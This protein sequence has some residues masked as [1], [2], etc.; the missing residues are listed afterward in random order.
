MDFIDDSFENKT[1]TMLRTIKR[2]TRSIFKP[3]ANQLLVEGLM[4]LFPDATL[5]VNSAGI[6]V[7]LNKAFAETTG[8]Q[9]DHILNSSVMEHLEDLDSIESVCACL[10]APHSAP[11]LLLRWSG[12]QRKSIPTEAHIKALCKT[13][14]SARLILLM[15]KERKQLQG[16]LL[17]PHAS[18]TERI[19]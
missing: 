19:L 3:S 18:M 17:F 10:N 6:I 14:S 2:L 9:Y 8:R 4:E 12:I 15:L 16:Q 7:A 13:Q 5:A 1:S 11:P